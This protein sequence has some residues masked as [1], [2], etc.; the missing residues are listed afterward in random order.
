VI[1]TL[2]A[3]LVAGLCVGW[4]ALRFRQARRFNHD[5]ATELLAALGRGGRERAERV[6]SERGGQWAAVAALSEVLEAP[7]HAYGV[8]IINEQLGDVRRELDVGAEVPRS[9]ARIALAAGT[10]LSVLAIAR[11][12]QRGGLMLGWAMAP[13]L[14][15]LVGAVACMQ[16]GRSA[17]RHASSHRDA[18]N[19]LRSVF[20]TLL[21]A[22]DAPRSA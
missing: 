15:G 22:E 2:I 3:V 12:L 20:T 17:E 4:S 8:A 14:V 19:G 1:S 13:F 6:A 10:V 11:G 18:W 7:T 21:P 9:A 16:L 5:G